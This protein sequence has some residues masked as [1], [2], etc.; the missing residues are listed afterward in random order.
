MAVGSLANKPVGTEVT[1]SNG[2]KARVVAA[3]RKDGTM[4]KRLQIFQGGNPPTTRVRREITPRGAK[5]AYTKYWKARLAAAGTPMQKRGVLSARGRDAKYVTPSTI[6]RTRTYL[7]NPGKYE[8]PGVDT[9]M[10]RYKKAT[11]TRAAA[12]AR[13]RAVLAQK[14]ATGGMS[15]I[16]YGA[17]R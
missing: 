16:Q 17:R 14:R 11:G 3:R 5:A 1:F 10:L 15:G 12:L 7:R 6:R 8:Y 2:A 13:G 9:G 4:Y